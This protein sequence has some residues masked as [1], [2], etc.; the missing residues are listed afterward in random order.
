MGGRQGKV[1]SHVT[2]SYFR[3]NNHHFCWLHNAFHR[4]LKTI[5]PDHSSRVVADKQLS[6]RLCSKSSTTKEMKH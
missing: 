4:L 1:V 2:S 5:E 6:V 3:I